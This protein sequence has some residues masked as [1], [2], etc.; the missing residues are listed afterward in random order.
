MTPQ[1]KLE[2]HAIVIGA[3][4]AGLL[5]ARALSAHFDR[6]T[7][8]E[9]DAVHPG[10]E[11]R[12]GQ[13]QTRHL[14]A[15]LASGLQ[16]VSSYFPD[17]VEA[18]QAG[19]AVILDAAETMRWH[20]YG[21]YRKPFHLGM[22]VA[23]MSRPFLESLVRQRTL[24]LPNVRLIDECAVQD[25]LVSADGGRVLGVQIER[26]TEQNQISLLEAN[27]VVDCSGRASRAPLWLETHGFPAPS[28]SEV[29][30]DVGYAT[31]VYRR[32][33][34]DPRGRQWFI[35]T[36][37]G[38][39]ETRFGGAFP[40]EGDRWILSVGGWGGDHA[41][42]EA[43]KFLEYIRAFPMPDLYAIAS[44]AEPV[45]DVIPYKFPSSLRH[46]YE[47]LVRFPDGFIVLGDAI[48][49]FN[50]T[51]G[52][53]VSS[54]ALQVAELDEL[55]SQRGGR[56]AG[57]A[58]EFFPRAARI[59]DTPWQMAVGEDFRF[60]TTSG[61]KPQGID[62]INRYTA[63]VH[64]ATQVDAEVCRTFL[65]VS[66]L[67]APPSALMAPRMLLRV[68]RANLARPTTRRSLVPQA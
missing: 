18:L 65:A 6:V 31:R 47:K 41:P 35:Y 25:I 52:Q 29:K 23:L 32:D 46:H 66:N 27:L 16:V 7:L 21:G 28:E 68:L 33:P 13:P 67:L 20:T 49:S 64:R 3:S 45:S 57:L 53:G 42:V 40:V 38:P 43:D 56:L 26:R 19:G 48:C 22:P 30:V 44:R 8:L 34:A 24:D 59:I 51:Y 62:L 63:L 36:P 54:A 2:T 61:P 12:K 15:L 50:P 9:R 39:A 4:M 60:P 37:Q 55:L 17:I 58:A 14:H 11:S 1:T 5:T 10:P